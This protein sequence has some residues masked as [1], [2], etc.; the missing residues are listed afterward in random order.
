VRQVVPG[1]ATR[2]LSNNRFEADFSSPDSLREL[3]VAVGQSDGAIVGGIVSFLALA[4]PF[5]KPGTE[6]L[7]APGQLASWMFQVAKQFG[8]DLQKSSENGGGWLINITALDGRLGCSGRPSLPVSQAGT[9]GILKT[10]AK[11]RPGLRVKTIDLDPSLPPEQLFILAV[12]ELLTPDDLVEVGIDAHG[13]W[14]IEPVVESLTPDQLGDLPVDRSSVI[15]ITG[16]AGGVTAS[17]A[18]EL[19][20]RVAPRLILIG[21]TPLP[22]PEAPDT[23]GLKDTPELRRHL[24][25][26]MQQRNHR[27]RPAD[28]EQ[29]LRKIVKD[30]E[31]LANLAA[32][33]A[34]G[35]VVEYHSVDVRDGEKFAALIDDVYTRHGKIDGVIHGAGIVRD[36][37]VRDKLPESFMEVFSTK[38][39]S[40]MVLAKRLRSDSLKFLVFFSS[41][42]GRFGNAGQVDYAAANEY[43]NKLA[44]HLDGEWPGRVVAVNW[45]PWN[46]GMVS[47]ELRRMYQSQG[48]QLIGLEAGARSLLDE[49]RITGRTT[50]EV[51]IAAG[52]AES[53][54]IAAGI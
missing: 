54:R 41:V 20:R 3:H 50:P 2:R 5:N 34:A 46:G 36:K 47:D 51:I 24:I 16:G 28:V 25:Q 52:T 30:R 35:G 13:R 7:S 27:V 31:I 11:E 18:R 33:Q 44:V 45:G 15:L 40:A 1:P 23:A 48:I 38:V 22:G 10:L 49:L 53:L 32:I 9:L 37:L 12:D 21:R 43:L 19:A 14:R 8:D 42:S 39:Q 17:V 26:V 6:D 29:A 4:E